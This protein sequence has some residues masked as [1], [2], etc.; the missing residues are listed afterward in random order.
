[1][2]GRML[3]V[4]SVLWTLR[5]AMAADGGNVELVGIEDDFVQLRLTG[6]CTVCPSAELTL[7]RGIEPAL[8]R[9]IPW[10]AGIKA[11]PL[12]GLAS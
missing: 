10:I 5:P 11:S 6:T 7:R 8:K 2:D 9:A 12:A 3:E 4:E 1:M